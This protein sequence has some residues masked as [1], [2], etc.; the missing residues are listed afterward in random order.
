MS[1]TL[2]VPVGDPK[3]HDIRSYGA[4][5]D[6]RVAFDV[7]MTSGSPVA[8][9][10]SLAFGPA[11]VGRKAVVAG[12]GTGGTELVA[13]I[14]SVDS[15]TTVTLS[16]NAAVTGSAFNTTIAT[17]DTAAVRAAVA[18]VVAAGGGVVYHPGGICLLAGA[19]LTG[20]VPTLGHAYSGVI[21]IPGRLRTEGQ[22][23]VI[24]KGA[25]PPPRFWYGKYSSLKILPETSATSIYQFTAT[26]GNGVEVLP[27]SVGDSLGIVYSN[28]QVLSRDM[29]WRFPNDPQCNGLNFFYACDSSMVDSTIGVNAPISEIKY[30]TG[31]AVGLNMSSTGVNGLSEARGLNIYGWPTAIKHSEH[32]LLD[33]VFIT[34]VLTGIEPNYGAHISHYQ[35]VY[36]AG[37]QRAI[38]MGTVNVANVHGVLSLEANPQPGGPQIACDIDDPAWKLQGRLEYSKF[39]PNEAP[40]IVSGG[41]K[42]DFRRLNG[43]SGRPSSQFPTAPQVT[44]TGMTNTTAGLPQMDSGQCF[45][46][47]GGTWSLSGGFAVGAGY[48]RVLGLNGTNPTVTATFT[49][50]PTGSAVGVSL[51]GSFNP[52]ADAAGD[53]FAH[54]SGGNTVTISKVAAGATS[55]LASASY[56]Y[57]ANSVQTMTVDYGVTTAGTV[58]VKMGGTPV[59][60]YALSGAEQTA[61]VGQKFV[62][63]RI[64]SGSDSGS[65][66]SAFSSV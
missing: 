50:G 2:G 56:S 32:T 41:G 54:I 21:I 60:T 42:C 62:G 40:L 23:A 12:A 66:F 24:F 27:N 33:N 64:V 45:T 44:F 52:T 58:T 31:T 55:V 8:S 65:K 61:Y 1:P 53:I 22:A 30:P 7:A 18:A 5:V 28:W 57:T 39:S 48:A 25:V 37:Y 49:T 11:D 4:R 13:T 36:V 43:F 59:V 3:V 63:M 35:K 46:T 47:F 19:P 51:L 6:G 15:S 17:D 38:K 16:A 14:L 26:S 9:S 34:W 20:T 29:L 10:S